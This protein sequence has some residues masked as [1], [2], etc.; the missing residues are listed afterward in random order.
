[1]IV[2]RL[3]HRFAYKILAFIIFVNIFALGICTDAV[4]FNHETTYYFNLEGYIIFNMILLI[5]CGTFFLIKLNGKNKIVIDIDKITIQKYFSKEVI[6]YSVTDIVGMQWGSVHRAM[7]MNQSVN[8]GGAALARSTVQNILV[9]FGGDDELL[10]NN[11]EYSNYE[12]LRD[13]FYSYCKKNNLIKE[14]SGQARRKARLMA[15]SKN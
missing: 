12:E 6:E 1:M 3:S 10:I 2:S 11:Y 8:R 4:E 15:R 9:L 13:F 7:S 5:V 14:T